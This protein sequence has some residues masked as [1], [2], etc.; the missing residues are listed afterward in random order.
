MRVPLCA[1]AGLVD[2]CKPPPPPPPP[3]VSANLAGASFRHRTTNGDAYTDAGEP[4]AKPHGSSD[5]R[6][7][8]FSNSAPMSRTYLRTTGDVNRLSESARNGCDWIIGAV[9]WLDAAWPN[10]AN[11]S[12][13]CLPNNEWLV[14]RAAVGPPPPPPPTLAPTADSVVEAAVDEDADADADE[15]KLE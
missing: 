12:L 11:G 10:R 5:K 15:D 8:S 2:E 13:A 1:S 4:P 3:S 9:A 6:A 7:S 14:V